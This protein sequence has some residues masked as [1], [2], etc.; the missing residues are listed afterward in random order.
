MNLG[1][2][3]TTTPMRTELQQ[4][5]R[6]G[7]TSRRG[8]AAPAPAEEAAVPMLTASCEELDVKLDSETP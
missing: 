7:C 4:T 2:A 8:E 3:T 1:F 6:I 5:V